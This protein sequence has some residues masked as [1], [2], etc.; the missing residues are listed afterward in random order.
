M[1][2]RRR[3]HNNKGA[4]GTRNGRRKKEVLV[5]GKRLGVKVGQ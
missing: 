3:H 2:G 5:I 4:R 1:K